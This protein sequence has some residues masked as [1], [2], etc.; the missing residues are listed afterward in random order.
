MNDLT[1]T[2]L[3]AAGAIKEDDGYLGII[4][5]LDLDQATSVARWLSISTQGPV[6]LRHMSLITGE[7]FID[8]TL[9]EVMAGVKKVG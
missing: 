9:E 7:T 5:G 3:V 1:I 8:L 2:A 4:Q 6:S